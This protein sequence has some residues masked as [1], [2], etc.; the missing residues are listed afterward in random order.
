MND[1]L[2]LITPDRL[3]A[4][5]DQ[6]ARANKR[7]VQICCTAKAGLEITYSFA[8]AYEI[9]HLRLALPAEPPPLPSI[10]GLFA[11]AFTYENEIHDLFGITF[12]NLTPDFGGSFYQL[13]QAT[14]WKAG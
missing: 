9:E 2:Q 14:P 13:K 5:V 6:R 7:L 10:T 4:E 8:Q 12:E 1:A 3:L 11:C